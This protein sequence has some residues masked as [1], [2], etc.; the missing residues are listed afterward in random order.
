[1]ASDSIDYY[2][3]LYPPKWMAERKLPEVVLDFDI[4]AAA[5]ELPSA[6]SVTTCTPEAVIRKAMVFNAL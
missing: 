1:M 5:A 3:E 6:D 2:E 4:H